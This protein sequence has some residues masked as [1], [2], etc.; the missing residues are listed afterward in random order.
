M[1]GQLADAVEHAG[2]AS[3]PRVANHSR[4]VE[5]QVAD[6]T[7]QPIAGQVRTRPVQ[8]AS[9]QVREAVDGPR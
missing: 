1:V 2:V 8:R 4:L 7:G 5:R 6:A 9:D 3:Q